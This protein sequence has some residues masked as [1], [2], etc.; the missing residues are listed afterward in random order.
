MIKAVLLD[1]DDTLLNLD[2][3]QFTRKYIAALGGFILSQYPGVSSGQFG[4]A[5][6]E[7]A[8]Q[9]IRNLDP[10]VLNDVSMVNAFGQSVGLDFDETTR[11]FTEFYR[12]HYDDLLSGL[13]P[14]EGAATL[15]EELTIRELQVVIATNPMF[16]AEATH[17]RL[18]KAGFEPDQ[19]RCVTHIENSH[20]AKPTQHYYEEIL[21]RIGI[22]AE[23]AIMVGDNPEND[24]RPAQQSGLATYWIDLERPLPEGL[25]PDAYGSLPALTARIQA[26]WLDTLAPRPRTPQQVSPRMLGNIAALESLTRELDERWWNVRPF[27]GEWTALEVMA[28]LADVEAPIH[29]A[30]LQRIAHEENPFIPPSPT[31][32]PAGTWPLAGHSGRELFMRFHHERQQT[33]AWLE[34]LPVEAWER[35][36]RH[37]LFGPTTLSEMAHFTARHDRL[38]INQLCALIGAC[39]E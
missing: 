19:F 26:G 1:L 3:D 18:R 17:R 23:D 24:M 13:L 7:G 5:I 22:E 36:G 34:S 9:T 32:P 21:A 35:P 2:T 38:H 25:S 8:Y 31:P 33:L 37:S 27:A 4:M 39:R 12:T 16:P 10:L 29:R 20:F 28:H 15:V 14:M 30:T 11:F 6:R